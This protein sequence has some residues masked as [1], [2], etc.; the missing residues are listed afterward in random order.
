MR[1]IRVGTIILLSLV[2]TSQIALAKPYNGSALFSET[3]SPDSI[4]LIVNGVRINALKVVDGP[5]KLYACSFYERQLPAFGGPGPVVVQVERVER[6]FLAI[7][8]Q[9]IE[10]HPHR[11]KKIIKEYLPHAPALHKRLGKPGFR[12]EN[13]PSMIQFYNRFRAQNPKQQFT[14]TSTKKPGV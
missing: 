7:A 3:V 12:Y 6:Y 1:A 14:S 9:F 2:F 4:R 8:D 11:Y 10:V 13:M 5:I